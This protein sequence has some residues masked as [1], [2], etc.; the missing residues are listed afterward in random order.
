MTRD[1][2]IRMAREAGF[3]RRNPHCDL[4]VIHSNGSWVGIEDELTRLIA[5]VAAEEREACAAIIQDAATAA[6]NNNDLRGY[7]LLSALGRAIRARGQ[8]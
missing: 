7:E 8:K 2:V 3:T 1:D 4:M 6:A 5:I